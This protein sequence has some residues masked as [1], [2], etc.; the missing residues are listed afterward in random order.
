MSEKWNH[1]LNN[2]PSLFSYYERRYMF[3]GVIDTCRTVITRNCV[4]VKQVLTCYKLIFEYKV[5][6]QHI[7]RTEERFSTNQNP[8]YRV[9]PSVLLVENH[10]MN[11]GNVSFC[12]TCIALHS[13][14]S[15]FGLIYFGSK[16]RHKSTR[17]LI[18]M[19]TPV[20]HNSSHSFY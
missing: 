8:R 20:W 6:Q 4:C 11:I 7:H 18:S 12:W 13:V 19:S 16:A 17:N 15:V 9:S 5:Q 1:F 3:N 14:Y 10:G 2:S